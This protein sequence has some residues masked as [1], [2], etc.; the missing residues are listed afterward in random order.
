MVITTQPMNVTVCLT[1]STTARFTCMVDRGGV[2]ISSAGWH[3]LLDGGIYVSVAGRPH[4]MTN[5]IRDG[6]IIADTLTVTNVS[7]DDN[8]TLYRCEPFGDVTSMS[9]II[10]VLGMYIT[11]HL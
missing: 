10:K 4:H 6:D 1:Q 2:G 8:G 7:V 11:I 9:V 3:I 5:A